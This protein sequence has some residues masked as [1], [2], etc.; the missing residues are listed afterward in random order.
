MLQ[1]ETSCARFLAMYK[2]VLRDW[3]WAEGRGPELRCAHH[4]GNGLILIALD[5]LN[6]DSGPEH[7]VRHLIIHQAQV[8]QYT[9]EEVYNPLSDEVQWG[10]PI[11]QAAVVDLGRSNWLLGFSQMHLARCRH[12][13]I[14]FYDEYLDIICE[15]ITA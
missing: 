15:N 5:Y 6:P 11:D 13:R 12:Y 4:R 14:M 2:P 7:D 9:P 3:I 10:P 8:H 1:A